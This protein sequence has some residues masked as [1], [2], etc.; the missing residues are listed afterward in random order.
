MLT[1]VFL[2]RIMCARPWPVSDSSRMEPVRTYSWENSRYISLLFKT[3]KKS[4]LAHLRILTMSLTLSSAGWSEPKSTWGRTCRSN[5]VGVVGGESLRSTHSGRW[6][7][8]VTCPGYLIYPYFIEAGWKSITTLILHNTLWPIY[9]FDLFLFSLGTWTQLSFS[10][11]WP[12]SSTAVR[13]QLPPRLL[14]PAHLPS[15]PLD[16]T[17]HRHCLEEAPWKLRLPARWGSSWNHPS[18]PYDPLNIDTVC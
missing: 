11:R 16:P 8:P 2:D 3:K 7:H 18:T 4:F 17:H 5:R 15:S 10:S 12:V 9:L 6:C 13:P 14:R 1:S